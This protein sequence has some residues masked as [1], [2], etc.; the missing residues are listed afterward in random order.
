M[1]IVKLLCG[2]GADLD[3]KDIVSL[4]HTC[5]SFLSMYIQYL[6][7]NGNVLVVLFLHVCMVCVGWTKC[8]ALG[9]EGKAPTSGAILKD[10]ASAGDI[11]E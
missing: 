8:S 2:K 3:A 6:L 4:S 11:L 9:V 5:S 10:V 1:A 7:V